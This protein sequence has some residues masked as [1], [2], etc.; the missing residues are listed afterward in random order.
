MEGLLEAERKKTAE[1]DATLHEVRATSEQL[2]RQLQHAE[3][4]VSSLQGERDALS[5][6]VNELNATLASK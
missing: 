4:V 2:S 3:E 1:Q 5:A 6:S